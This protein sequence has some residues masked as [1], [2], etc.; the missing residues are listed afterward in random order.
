MSDH[1]FVIFNTLMKNNKEDGTWRL[2]SQYKYQI[3]P[4][5]SYC[6]ASI[7]GQRINKEGP[8]LYAY[9]HNFMN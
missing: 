4:N 3:S 6:T 9:Y 5:Y 1:R 7:Q 2:L 8:N